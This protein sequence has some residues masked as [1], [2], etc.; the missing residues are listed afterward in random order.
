MSKYELIFEPFSSILNALTQEE[1]I[2]TFLLSPEIKLEQRL[3]KFLIHENNAIRL[4]TQK[5]MKH[6]MFSHEND[7]L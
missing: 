5:T 3:K 2:R 4:A 6:L 1:D 7:D